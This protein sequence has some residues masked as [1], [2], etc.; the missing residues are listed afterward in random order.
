MNE[1]ILRAKESFKYPMATDLIEIDI[2]WYWDHRYDYDAFL[3]QVSDA[4][5]GIAWKD[6]D[7]IVK[8][9]I[10]KS[11]TK[12]RKIKYA[13]LSETGFDLYIRKH[14]ATQTQTPLLQPK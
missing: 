3:K 1:I 7:L 12:H 4:L 5:S 9:T 13:N 14:A 11:F 8:A 2:T 10:V 6:D